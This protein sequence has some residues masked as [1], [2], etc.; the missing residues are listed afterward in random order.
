VLPFV[1]RNSSEASVPATLRDVLGV[2]RYASSSNES[3]GSP[4]DVTVFVAQ[5]AD[6]AQ[7]DKETVDYRGEFVLTLTRIDVAAVLPIEVGATFTDGPLR[8][9]VDRLQPEESG[10]RMHIRTSNVRTL[11]NRSPRPVYYYFLRNRRLSE[12]SEANVYR[13]RVVLEPLYP[14]ASPFEVSTS[15]VFFGRM[16]WRNEWPKVGAGHLQLDATWMD[17]AELVVIR[18]VA[19]GMLARALTM[20]GVTLAVD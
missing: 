12:A 20:S 1:D 7:Y 16:V 6:I 18:T 15:E 4:G 17:D 14:R 13:N 19:D 5:T 10:L 8:F 9:R 11:F 3:V 2:R